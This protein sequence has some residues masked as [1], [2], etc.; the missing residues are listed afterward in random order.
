MDIKKAVLNNLKG[1]TKEEIKGFI[2]Q[3]IDS[4]EENAI[5][6][7]GVI[8]EAMWEKMTNEEK[9]SMMNLIMRGVS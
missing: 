8:F 6:G 3:V 2:Q 9:D 7:L 1:R 5:P 4:K